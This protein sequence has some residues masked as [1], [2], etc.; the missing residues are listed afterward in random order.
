MCVFI[1]EVLV[2]VQRTFNFTN[3]IKS[4]TLT[5]SLVSSGLPRWRSWWRMHQC[6]RGKRHRFNSWVETTP[7]IKG[8]APHS[9]V[10]AWRTPWTEEPGVLQS[11]GPERVRHD[12]GYTHTIWTYVQG[13]IR[14]FLLYGYLFP[15]F[16]VMT[17]FAIVTSIEML[18]Q[19]LSITI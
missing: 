6:R 3:E 1:E 18:S 13:G 5:S 15:G 2:V 8:L 16:N 7:W 17:T 10:L 14:A 4:Q 12:W 19:H 9:S 11:P